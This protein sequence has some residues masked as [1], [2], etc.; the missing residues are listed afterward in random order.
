MPAV[1]IQ[2]RR[3]LLYISFM[4]LHS[5]SDLFFYD[6]I[7]ITNN[8]L[9]ILIYIILLLLILQILHQKSQTKEQIN[10]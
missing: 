3:N 9:I 2:Q 7:V 6:F 5:A 8:F 4:A 1:A 10:I